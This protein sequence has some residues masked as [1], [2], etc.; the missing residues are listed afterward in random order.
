MGL[1][2]GGP[3][4]V[5]TAAY[6]IK[7]ADRQRPAAGE[8]LRIVSAEAETWSGESAAARMIDSSGFGD[9]NGDGLEEH[10]TSA[11]DMWLSEK[12]Q[13]GGSI[14]LD[15]G[16]ER[17]VGRVLVWNYNERYFTDRGIGRADV[18]VWTESDGWKKVVEGHVFESAEGSGSYDEPTVIEM[19]GVRGAKIR[20]ENIENLGDA[21]H[22]G[23]SEV[24]VYERRGAKAALIGPAD[25]AEH[26]STDGMRVVWSAGEGAAGHRVYAGTSD[27]E[28]GMVCAIDEDASVNMADLYGLVPGRKYY[29]RV[30]S[31]LGDGTTVKGNVRSFTTGKLVG[32]WKFD[33]SEGQSA[34]DSS[35][36]GKHGKLVGDCKWAPGGGR[37]GG[38]IA[39]DGDGDYVDMGRDKDFDLTRAVTISCWVKVEKFDKDWQAVVTK[40]DTAWRV[41][42]LQGTDNMAFRCNSS[43]GPKGKINVN[44]GAWHH[45]V[46]SYDG[47]R[48]CLYVDGRLDSVEAVSGLIWTNE[49]PV[50]VGLNAEHRGR[51]WSGMIDDVRIYS[52]GLSAGEV[53]MLFEGGSGGGT[54][55]GIVAKA[56]RSGADV[57]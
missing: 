50:L 33:E 19:G 44:D 11:K 40:G 9:S 1:K 28:L 35:G 57:N 21:D 16:G 10:S 38:A 17:H 30:D 23:L 53:N 56:V 2:V 39:F 51:G 41:Q 18:S 37:F 52:Y 22:V 3:F 43:W 31:V 8:E 42:R 4:R 7:A 36:N 32:W 34:S 14:V 48:A 12:G 46:G 54:S 27:G 47:A 25:G 20:L 13:T 6:H 55:G 5:H 45:V 26:C 15:L 49:H 29:W 24:R